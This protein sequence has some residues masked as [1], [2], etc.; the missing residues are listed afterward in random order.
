MSG[1]HNQYQKGCNHVWADISSKRQKMWQCSHCDLL[2]LDPPTKETRE[3]HGLTDED[4][5]ELVRKT[6]S[7]DETVAAVEAKLKEKNT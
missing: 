2:R 3:W 5:W 6:P 4:R 1:D 7:F